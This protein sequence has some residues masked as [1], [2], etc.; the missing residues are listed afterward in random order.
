MSKQS[1]IDELNGK[2]FDL[3][4]QIEFLTR[5]REKLQ[6]E[7]T[8]A[9]VRAT[10]AEGTARYWLEQHDNVVG[11]LRDMTRKSVAVMGSMITESVDALNNQADHYEKQIFAVKGLA[12]L[13]IEQ[14]RTDTMADCF[15]HVTAKLAERS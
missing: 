7:A 15:A 1:T 6:R 5:E 9:N 13:A 3:E 11:A 10:S 14:A 8:A 12:A 4:T 2:V